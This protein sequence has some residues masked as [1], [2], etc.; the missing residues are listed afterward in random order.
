MSGFWIRQVGKNQEPLVLGQSALSASVFD[1]PCHVAWLWVPTR[2][3]ARGV[4]QCWIRL[5][6]TMS[7]GWHSLH[8]KSLQD[9]KR[10]S[11]RQQPGKKEVS[12]PADKPVMNRLSIAGFVPPSV[13][14]HALREKGLQRQIGDG[15]LV[16]SQEQRAP[17]F[18]RLNRFI[19][20]SSMADFVI[21]SVYIGFRYSSFWGNDETCLR[22]FGKYWGRLFPGRTVLLAYSPARPRPATP[23]CALSRRASGMSGFWLQQ[24][25]IGFRLFVLLGGRSGD[26]SSML[27]MVQERIV[28]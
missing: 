27:W 16:S 12:R 21:P 28:P 13:P 5:V 3:A 23:P 11:T 9:K 6:G 25:Y 22:C 1:R 15:P 8:E 14:G 26:V 10:R 17:F 2:L 18:P 20:R 7:T 4:L 19:N 24:V